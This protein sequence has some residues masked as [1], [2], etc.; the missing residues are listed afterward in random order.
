VQGFLA[1]IGTSVGALQ[2]EFAGVQGDVSALETG[3]V[4]RWRADL[5]VNTIDI[6]GLESYIKF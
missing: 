3:G 1:D 2:T 6:S 4:A 5:I